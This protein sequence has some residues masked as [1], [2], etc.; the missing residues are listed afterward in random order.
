MRTISAT[1]L[2]A[3]QSWRGKPYVNAAIANKRTRWASQR[4]GDGSSQHTDM[5]AIGDVIWRVRGSSAGA[6]QTATVT[7][8]ATSAQWIAWTSQA[9]GAINNSP[10]AIASPYSLEIRL[11]YV[12]ANGGNY[13]LYVIFRRD[14]VW[15]TPA[16]VVSGLTAIPNLAASGEYLFY[17]TAL[18]IGVAYCPT[19]GDSWDILTAWTASPVPATWYGIAAT[20]KTGVVTVIAAI[21]GVVVKGTYTLLTDAWS[22]F[23]QIA[24]GGTNAVPTTGLTLRYPGVIWAGTTLFVTWLEL[25]SSGSVAWTYAVLN[26][27]VDGLHFGCEAALY[28]WSNTDRRVA[29]A[30]TSSTRKVYAGNEKC[31][32]VATLYDA[33]DA[34]T[35]LADLA[36]SSYTRV[37]NEHGSRLRLELLNVGG[38]YNQPGT[39]GQTAAPAAPLAEVILNRGY[40][41][42]ATHEEQPLDPHYIISAT[43]VHGMEDHR[44]DIVAVDGWGL[45]ELW[46]PAEVQTYTNQTIRWLLAELCARVGLTYEDD[47]GAAL[48]ATISSLTIHPAQ[49]AADAARALLLLAGS[50]AY[51]TSTG[52]FHALNL[53]ASSPVNKV[54]IGDEA[55]S[56][57]VGVLPNAGTS[58]HIYGSGFTAT[59]ELGAASMSLG[60]R[61]HRSVQDYRLTTQAE[62]N[63]VQNYLW[64]RG[65]G[66]ACKEVTTVGLRPDAEMWDLARLMMDTT[67]VP[68]GNCIRRIIAIT[69]QYD[70]QRNRFHSIITTEDN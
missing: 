56:V 53:Y 10:V 8:P 11:F 28:I 44:L 38:R 65:S 18:T 36:V 45:L 31:V 47:L 21:N 70:P 24:P 34:T 1:L 5:V 7:V 43:L 19:S 64:T 32:M 50:V 59:A 25:Y 14:S 12:V 51:F 41:L 3:A 20:T 54:D 29:F 15:S 22:A 27:S 58:F 60:L 35:N 26:R 63:A 9:T 6:V 48:G 39:A 67:I 55:Q 2:A 40:K 49:S 46:Q 37:T 4:T 16:A 66:S 13:D 69:E 42:A 23:A 52:V 33:S 30:Y 17:T 57:S 62:A 68:L 61:L